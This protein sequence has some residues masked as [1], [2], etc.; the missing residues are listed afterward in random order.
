MGPVAL[1]AC[2]TP[3]LLKPELSEL[4]AEVRALRSD[5]LRLEARIEMLER[6]KAVAGQ[7]G[8][9]STA[10]H[11]VAASEAH[12]MPELTVVKL[13]PKREAAPKVATSVAV[14]EPEPEVISS[15]EQVLPAAQ[16]AY[17]GDGERGDMV[18]NNAVNALKTGNVEG[19]IAQLQ[20]F[21]VEAPQHAKADNALY[22]SGLGY[23]GLNDFEDAATAF[24][25]VAKKYPAG[26][27]VVDALL[28]L[29]ECRTKMNQPADARKAY[30]RIVKDW[31]DTP[32][33]QAARSR[34]S[35]LPN[36][37]ASP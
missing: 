12:A 18:F 36:P 37:A 32:A 10:G 13:K 11:A 20:Q 35:S 27:A 14:I 8:S 7:S 24:E 26:D 22:F 19:G 1:S 17:A 23:M 29:A 3:A 21:A 4:Q 5:N 34:L 30:Q 6:N 16:S 28:K 31:P 9:L 25:S 2:A 33:A 15:L